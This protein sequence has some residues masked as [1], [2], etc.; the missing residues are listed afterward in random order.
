MADSIVDAM[1]DDAN[2]GWSLLM[3]HTVQDGIKIKKV[4]N[5]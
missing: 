3:I 2:L 4:P 5:L 1:N